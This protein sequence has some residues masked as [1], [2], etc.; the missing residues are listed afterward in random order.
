M[1]DRKA[2]PDRPD[3]NP[4]LFFRRWLANPREVGSV[5]PSSPALKRR[6]T[7]EIRR[8]PDEYV[9]E[10]GGGTGAITRGILE[11]GVPADRLYVLEINP[12]MARHLR[13]TFPGIHVIEGDARRLGEILPPEVVGK[14][15]TTLC[16]IP[17]LL[18]THEE[19][20]A[21]LDSAYSV[22][23]KG[24]QVVLY[25]YAF[26]SPLQRDKLGLDGRR[27]GFVT[28]NIPPASVWAYR[29]RNAG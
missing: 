15:G 17:M 13:E 29:Q 9:V 3:M 1:T 28:A 25:T 16:G 18:L 6:L 19:Q 23:P 14:V 21:I 8:A 27:V 20:Q 24:R 26:S 7:Q 4:W 11:R 2:G 12:E 10:L 22:M 5:T